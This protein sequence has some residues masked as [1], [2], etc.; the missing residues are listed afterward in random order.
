[1]TKTIEIADWCDIQRVLKETFEIWSPGLSRENYADFIR[2]Q[3][4]HPWCKQNYSYLILRDQFNSK[5][6]A[7]SLKYYKLNFK[8]NGRNYKFAGFG[9]IYT[10][11]DL[12]GLG[13]ATELIKQSLD[14][15][16]YDGCHGAILFS[17]I[18]T[19]YYARIGFF[20]CNNEKF[21]IQLNDAQ[22]GSEMHAPSG[23]KDNYSATGDTN[24]W[25]TNFIVDGET[26]VRCRYLST[27]PEMIDFVARHYRRWLRKQEFG[28]ERSEDYFHFKISRENYLAEHSSLVWPK[29]ELLTVESPDATGYAIIEYG[30]RVVRI[31]ELIGDFN[32]R[33]LL[34]K[35][36]I[37]RA[38]DLE[39]IRISGWE[40]ILTDFQ[41]GFSLNQMGTLDSSLLLDCR[42]LLFTD[43]LRGRTMILP[44]YEE[45]EDWITVC[46]CPVL[47]LDHL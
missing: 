33:R 1:M 21:I 43:K 34:W 47:E 7:A 36:I 32:T 39:A 6:P 24:E 9:A 19:S 8:R 44:F 31:L 28:I 23:W 20:D 14:R 25:S 46:P 40:A 11:K 5:T 42:N 22:P 2:M 27:N 15:A 16:W 18:G 13:Y 41:P 29:L 17:D 30:G 10:R 35:G 38:R 12:R 3:M 45:I 37:A 26:I 4:R